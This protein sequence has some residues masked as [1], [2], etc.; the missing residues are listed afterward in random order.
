MV[1]EFWKPPGG[2]NVDRRNL[3]LADWDGDGACDIIWVDP[4]RNN[5]VRVF[6]NKYKR[7][8]KWTF[9]ETAAPD[10]QCNEKDGIGIH[11]G[12]YSCSTFGFIC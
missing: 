6:I 4:Q 2:A 11:D 7:D 12:T 10:L 1:S 5:R 3:H 8:K 9:E